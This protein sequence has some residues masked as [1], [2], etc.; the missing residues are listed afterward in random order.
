M[1]K[2]LL[3]KKIGMTRIFLDSDK[4]IPTTVVEAG[5]CY[6]VEV[7]SQRKKLTLGFETVKEHRL[8]KAQKGLFKKAGLPNL[9]NIKQFDIGEEREY[10]VG[11]E[12]KADIFTPGDYVDVTGVTKGKGFQGGVKRWHWKGGPK[13]HGSMSHRR[14]GSIGA[15]SDPSRVFKGQHMPGHMG[16]E[17]LTIQNMEVLKVNTDSNVLILKGSIPGH[18]N[19]LLVIRKAKKKTRK[20]VSSAEKSTEGS[21]KDKK[22]TPKAKGKGKK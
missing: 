8:K 7:N 13:S 5:P 22:T 3:G 2:G 10:K 21:E 9:K 4:A 18:Q 16:A 20:E 1:S 12:L 6:V 11:E 17:Q 19:S 14:V 15:S